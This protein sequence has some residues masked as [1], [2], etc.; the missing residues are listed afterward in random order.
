ME[1]E[2]D[3]EKELTNVDKH[4]VAFSEASTVF[5]DPF[6][7]TIPDPDHSVGEYR[8]LSAGVSSAGRVLVVS[9]LE[10]TD[11]R[12]RIISARAASRR[13]RRQYETG[14]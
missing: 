11:N 9:F 12:I 4:G 14:V 3:G 6:E 8:F 1:F 5:G 7:V 10:R 2:W 13:E